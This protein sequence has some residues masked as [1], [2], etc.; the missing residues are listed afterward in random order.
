MNNREDSIDGGS[1]YRTNVVG[2]QAVLDAC[3]QAGTEHFIL[4]SSSTVYGDRAPLPF[5]EDCPVACRPHPYA[6]SKLLAERTAETYA[7]VCGIRVT[8]LRA[9]T[10][11]GPRQRPGTVLRKF[12]ELI[13]AGEPVPLIGDGSDRRDYLYVDDCV[14]GVMRAVDHPFALERINLGCGKATS[15]CELVGIVASRLGR[16]ARVRHV[17]PPEGELTASCADVE[18]AKR[19]LGF[20]PKV[21][22]DEG[23]RRFVQ[24]YRR[25]KSELGAERPLR[26]LKAA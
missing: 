14:E 7:Q 8:I 17:P 25:G 22:I 1:F 18:R 21:Q 19:L 4:V 10:V 26:S 23:V 15:I 11:Y 3:R 6:L 24:W 13:D 5:R 9:F 2:T 16:S 12:V 20:Q